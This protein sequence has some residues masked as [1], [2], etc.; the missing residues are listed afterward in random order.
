LPRTIVGMERGLQASERTPRRNVCRTNLGGLSEDGGPTRDK[1]S[2]IMTVELLDRP[3][4]E[5]RQLI[6]TILIMAD[7]D[8]TTLPRG[9]GNPATSED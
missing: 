1:G 2:Q 3:A 6:S 8:G 7:E 5:Q 4:E 9:L